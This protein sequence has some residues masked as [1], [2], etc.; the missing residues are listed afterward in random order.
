MKNN[1]CRLCWLQAALQAAHPPV[2]TEADLAG[3]THHQ[4]FFAS[5]TKMRGPRSGAR[6]R[7]APQPP[8]ASPESTSVC[9][10]ADSGQLQLQLPGPGRA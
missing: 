9:R 3:V 5:T 8:P 1:Y 10:R 7:A 4:L 6:H 2:V